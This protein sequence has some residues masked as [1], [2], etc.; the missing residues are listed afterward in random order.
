MVRE[1]AELGLSSVETEA[2]IIEKRPCYLVHWPL[3]H[4]SEDYQVILLK[5]EENPERKFFLLFNTDLVI[6]GNTILINFYLC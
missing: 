4:I 3:S 1:K 5:E 6:E 2:E